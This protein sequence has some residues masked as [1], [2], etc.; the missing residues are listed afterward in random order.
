MGTR[1]VLIDRF[2]PR[3]DVSEHHATR[4][5]ASAERIYDVIRHGELAT[6]PV[7]RALLFLR[8]MGRRPRTTFSLELFLQEGFTLVAEDRP[9]E[10]VLAL[11]GPFWRAACKVRP[12]QF[13]QPVPSG[14]ARAAW[15]FHVGE[16]VVSTETRVLCADDARAKFR[17]YWLF[18]RPFSGL[19]RRM[20]LRAIRREA[21]RG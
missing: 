14:S 13:D 21:E 3:Y 6:H 5:G 20:M 10:I 2:L 11:E 4:V 8:G 15:N 12:P 17:L 9:R 16:G 18:I 1:V 19:I 7:V